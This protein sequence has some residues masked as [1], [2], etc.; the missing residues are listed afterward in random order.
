VAP[1]NQI[2]HA[3]RVALRLGGLG[4]LDPAAVPLP[5]RTEVTT[6]VERVVNG[7]LRPAG[8]AGRVAQGAAGPDGELI[9]VVFIDGRRAHY[10]RGELVPRKLGVARYAHR[11]AA[12]WQELHGCV[13]LDELTPRLEAAR[14]TSPLPGH[15]DIAR[16]ERLLRAVR[17][18]A[19]RRWLA[20]TPGPWGAD[21]AEPPQ[22]EFDGRSRAVGTL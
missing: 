7:E 10:L 20:R 12:S 16:A 14:Q 3:G 9:E 1:V 2:G 18:E 5:A 11:R 4:D 6:R 19:A 21:A 8:A 15:G 22:P 13:V 17:D